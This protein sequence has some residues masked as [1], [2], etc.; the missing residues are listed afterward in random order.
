MNS[1]ST[2]TIVPVIISG[3]SGS[4]L[5]P[6][7][8]Q[9]LPKPFAPLF[10]PNLFEQTLNRLKP[11]HSPL[12]VTNKKLAPLTEHSL[13]QT[14]TQA[15]CLYEPVAK[16]T[17]PA[18]AWA[19]VWA[20][21]H[22]GDQSTLAI[23]PADHWIGNMNQF[24]SDIVQAEKIAQQGYLVVLGIPPTHPETGYGYIEKSDRISDTLGFQVKAF[25]EKPS[26]PV[27]KQYIEQGFFWNAG[28]FVGQIKTFAKHIEQFYPELWTTLVKHLGQLQLLEQEFT[29]FPEISFDYAILEKLTSKDLAV[30]PARFPWSDVGTWDSVSQSKDSNKTPHK[31]YHGQN[32]VVFGLKNKTYRTLGVNDLIIADT[33]DGLL[34]CQKGQSQKVSEVYKDLKADQP[35]AIERHTF[36]QRP[37]GDFRV[38][39]DD[40]HYKTKLIQV[41]PGAM[42]SYQSHNHRSEHWVVVQ[43]EAEVI[44]DGVSHRLKRGDYI[45]IKQGQKHRL[46]NPGKELLQVVEVQIGNYLSEDDITRYEDRYGR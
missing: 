15:N 26:E 19:T 36:E 6:F 9:L 41:L 24:H 28:I 8:R 33:E 38:L 1:P 12:I 18:I 2:P 16:N 32:N 43:G 46:I 35:A 31:E 37:W 23:F 13:K 39:R 4:R 40:N 17:M 3:G 22:H 42:L 45:F 29:R 21:K 20:L 44:L 5:W 7:S 10:E 34:I 14:N 25:H 27:A 30:L 11:W